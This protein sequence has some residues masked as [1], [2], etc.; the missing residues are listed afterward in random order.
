M[1]NFFLYSTVNPFNLTWFNSPPPSSSEKK[2]EVLKFS[3]SFFVRCLLVS[4]SL[5]LNSYNSL[6]KFVDL[7]YLRSDDKGFTVLILQT[8]HKFTFSLGQIATELHSDSVLYT[9]GLTWCNTV[10]RIL[11][12]LWIVLC[13]TDGIEMANVILLYTKFVPC[14][15]KKYWQFKASSNAIFNVNFTLFGKETAISLM[16]ESKSYMLW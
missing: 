1:F 14:R 8:G 6:L 4:W 13:L 12:N 16:K 2:S 11:E 9:L 7:P 3:C 15:N 10:K 5:K